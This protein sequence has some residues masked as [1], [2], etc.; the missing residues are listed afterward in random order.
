MLVKGQNNFDSLIDAMLKIIKKNGS[1]HPNLDKPVLRDILLLF[2]FLD[3]A[4]IAS[5]IEVPNEL[6]ES[7]H[8]E[9]LEIYVQHKD[10]KFPGNACTGHCKYLGEDSSN[11]DSIQSLKTH[12]DSKVYNQHYSINF[13]FCELLSDLLKMT[14]CVWMPCANYPGVFSCT[15]LFGL[16]YPDFCFVAF[17]PYELEVKFVHTRTPG[18]V[19][20]AWTMSEDD[21]ESKANFFCPIEMSTTKI[22]IRARPPTSANDPA[23]VF[24]ICDNN[25]S[26]RDMTSFDYFAI[27]H[28]RN[29]EYI[30]PN[31]F[32]SSSSKL[33]N[34]LSQHEGLFHCI[35][36]FL[37]Y[38]NKNPHQTEKSNRRASSSSS[39]LKNTMSGQKGSVRTNCFVIVSQIYKNSTS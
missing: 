38:T 4:G 2:A 24:A 10:V 12:W 22:K 20:Q 1:K 29:N 28:M 19:P 9:L 21:I 13:S 16:Q 35:L 31:D 32:A 26:I 14:I 37:L 3:A 36:L 8:Y 17:F 18:G 39:K 7:F 25:D 30:H 34:T 23:V 33:K 27:S 15:T 5:D 11:F 6:S